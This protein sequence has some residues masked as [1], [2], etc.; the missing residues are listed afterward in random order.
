MSDF[1]SLQSTP[2][3][4]NPPKGVPHHLANR[5]SGFQALRYKLP[6]VYF[7]DLTSGP[8][9]SALGVGGEDTAKGVLSVASLT[10]IGKYYQGWSFR[11]MPNMANDSEETNR[12]S[13]RNAVP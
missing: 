7:W 8:K 2:T 5:P 10:E 6:F 4:S 9:N 1:F 3:S 13:T 11:N 12:N